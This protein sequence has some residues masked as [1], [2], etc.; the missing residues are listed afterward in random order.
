[1]TASFTI[2][3][4]P[5]A[6]NLI[7]YPNA[8]DS[9]THMLPIGAAANYL[10]VDEDYDIPDE[11]T[12][13]VYTKST[14]VVTDVYRLPNHTSETGTINYVKVYARTKSNLYTQGGAGIF[15]ILASTSALTYY[16]S[17]INL[18]TD[19]TTYNNIWLLN[20]ETSLAWTWAD[21]DNLKIGIAASSPSLTGRSGTLTLRPNAHGRYTNL[22]KYPND[23][24]NYD[25]VNDDVPDDAAT[26]V[27]CALGITDWYTDTY[28]IENVSFVTTGVDIN[29]VKIYQRV[30]GG[31]V[32]SGWHSHARSVLSTGHYLY[33]GTDRDITT[34]PQ[35]WQDYSDTWT[36]NP[37]TL[38]AWNWTDINNLEIGISLKSYY[39]Y[40]TQLYAYISYDLDNY[41]PEIRT[42][43][44]YAVVNYAASSTTCFLSKPHSYTYSNSRQVNKFNTW[45]GERKVYDVTRTSKM[46]V[47]MGIEY[48]R[49]DSVVTTTLNCVRAMK[50]N[51]TYITITGTGDT[52]VDTTW[53]IQDFSFAKN[54]SNPYI[55]DWVLT[56]E[57]YENV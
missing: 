38:A 6:N 15:K 51:G 43:Q 31:N 54:E 24:Y 42:T 35:S 22:E 34:T 9:M 52:L 32:N 49:P 13:Y 14:S 41:S 10:C 16:S 33:Y 25:K 55:Y 28:E 46:L 7:L 18:S 1:M 8:A 4:T 44:C 17:D 45:S 20:P 26:Y 23:T 12:T 47:M 11:D 27:Y 29:S 2:T 39:A 56:L 30:K 48:P 3:Q 40:C 36:S 19:Y 57:R 37:S 21:I 50:D 53:M 5:L